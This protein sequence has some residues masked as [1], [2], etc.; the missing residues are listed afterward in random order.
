MPRNPSGRSMCTSCPRTETPAHSRA[1]ARPRRVWGS[2]PVVPAAADSVPRA[3]LRANA[4]SAHADRRATPSPSFRR[5]RAFRHCSEH[6]SARPEG[7]GAR[8][9]SP[10]GRWLP[11][12]RFHRRPMTLPRA[13]LLRLTAPAVCA[14][15]PTSATCGVA[16][17]RF[18]VVSPSPSFSPSP[19]A[20]LWPLLTSR[21]VRLAALVALSDTRRDLPG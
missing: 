5:C 14:L 15:G 20:R 6:A 9:P 11:G 3:I 1:R 18:M 8:T 12:T 17:S 4:A 13:R 10:S 16:S 2:P 19:L 7:Y 21:S